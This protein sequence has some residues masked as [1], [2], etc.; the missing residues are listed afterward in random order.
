VKLAVG[1]RQTPLPQRVLGRDLFR[2]LEATGL[3]NATV[4]SRIGQ[5]MNDRETLIGSSPRAARKTGITIRA[6]ATHAAGS[7]V[8]FADGGRV[9]VDAV[10]WATGFERDSR[11]S[12]RRRSTPTAASRTSAASRPA[13][14]CT[15]SGCRGNT[16]ADRR[17][18]AGSRTTPN[19]SRGTSARWH[20]TS[21]PRPTRRSFMAARRAAR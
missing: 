1:S 15:S 4:T 20:D 5:R 19:T 11:G 16:R 9:D 18:S 6:G 17:Y 2:F 8:T 7:T 13:R 3:M 21:V 10:I 12:T 14:A